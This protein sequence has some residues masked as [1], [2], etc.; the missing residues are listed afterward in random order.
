M[1]TFSFWSKHRLRIRKSGHKRH[2]HIRICISA[3]YNNQ[4]VNTNRLK[5]GFAPEIMQKATFQSVK[6]YV[7]HHNSMPFRS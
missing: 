5:P 4:A 3:V 6:K 7:L 1:P 2:L